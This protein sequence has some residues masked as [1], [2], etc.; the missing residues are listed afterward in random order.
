MSS[1]QWALKRTRK[2][3]T[4][5]A[6]WQSAPPA[7]CWVC[8]CWEW[9]FSTWSMPSDAMPSARCSSAPT[10]CWSFAMIWLVMVGLVLVTAAR[11]NIALDFLVNRLG[12]RARTTST[13]V[14]HAILAIACGYAVVQS[15][16]FVRR[17][18]ALDQTSMALGMPMR[19]PAFRPARRIWRGDD[20]RRRD[21][22][23]GAGGA[24]RR[25]PQGALA[26]NDLDACDPADHAAVPR[27][28][29][30]RDLSGQRRPRPSRCSFR[31]RR[32]RCIR[33]CSAASRTTRCWRCRSSSS[34]AS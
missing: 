5:L 12:P 11:A 21:R 19:D 13:I 31:C 2:P 20:R 26:A 3:Y 25:T 16:A 30:L 33:S 27:R 6:A 14:N 4:G 34:P 7:S 9:S 24:D 28:A 15:F 32:S 17:L 22:R 29:D 1:P 8:C 23:Q 18:T 10:N